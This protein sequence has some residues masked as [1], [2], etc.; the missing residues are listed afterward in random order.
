MGIAQGVAF[1]VAHGFE[2]LIDPN[3]GVDGE[4]FLREGRERRWACRRGDDCPEACDTH[5]A[6]RMLSETE[7]S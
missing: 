3:G 6:G 2:E 1:L 4:A 7:G 5:F